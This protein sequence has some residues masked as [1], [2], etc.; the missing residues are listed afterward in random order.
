VARI[1]LGSA[2]ARATHAHIIQSSRQMFEQGDF[3]SLASGA[4]GSEIEA[5]FDT[6]AENKMQSL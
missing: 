2:L 6:F 4:S 1:S 3:S 5:M